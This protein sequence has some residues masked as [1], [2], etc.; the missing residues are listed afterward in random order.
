MITT[1][2]LDIHIQTFLKHLQSFVGLL[3][4][5]K[6]SLAS[7]HPEDLANAVVNMVVGG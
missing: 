4:L 1:K 2:H 3:L 5:L 6:M 7:L